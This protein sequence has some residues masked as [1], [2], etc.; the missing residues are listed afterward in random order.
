[1]PKIYHHEG[2]RANVRERLYL[3]DERIRRGDYPSLSKLAKFCA[4]SSKTV[5]RD[6]DYL[7]NIFGAPL[8]YDDHEK[9]WY[10]S[11]KT[12]SLSTQYA[13]PEELQSLLV[14]GEILKQFES[15]PLGQSLQHSYSRLLGLFKSEAPARFRLLARRICFVQMSSTPVNDDSWKVILKALQDDQIL[16][17][18]YA[19]GGQGTGKTRRFDPYGLIVRGRDWYLYGYNHL[20]KACRTLALPF[21]Q[22]VTA[23]DEYFVLPAKFDIREYSN[24]GF[25]GLQADGEPK[26]KIVLRFDADVAAIIQSRPF[27]RNQIVKLEADGTAIVSF[28]ASA[29]FQVE[30]EVLSYGDK[31]EVLAPKELRERAAA[32]AQGLVNKYRLR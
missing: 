27:A 10:Y 29:L 30:R 2:E 22:S 16:E 25:D 8:E 18:T 31:V 5:Q 24:A 17:I 3:I 21:I 28:A 32:T 26:H 20:S 6:V 7:R 12:Y 13:T 15:T 1:M 4:V 23:L 14:L 11:E 9:G 19:R